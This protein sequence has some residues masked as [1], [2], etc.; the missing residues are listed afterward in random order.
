VQGTSARCRTSADNA[1]L[2][3]RDR[4]VESSMP[5]NCGVARWLERTARQSIADD[6]NHRWFVSPQRRHYLLDRATTS[7]CPYVN[8][9]YAVIDGCRSA[10]PAGSPSYWAVSGVDLREDIHDD[11]TTIA[12]VHPLP[13]KRGRVPASLTAV[14]AGNALHIVSTRHAICFRAAWPAID[15]KASPRISAQETTYIA[16]PSPLREWLPL[17]IISA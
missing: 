11:P 2:K 6:R 17:T 9:V 3:L 15:E 1:L 4:R 7:V 16:S 12:L 10:Y 14:G 8:V 13:T 5:N